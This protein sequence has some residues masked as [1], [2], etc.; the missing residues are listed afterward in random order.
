MDEMIIT[1]ARY[2]TDDDG[3]NISIVATI[4]GKRIGFPIWPG[5]REYDET[6]RQVEEG[7]LTIAEAD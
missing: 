7:T 2:I 5:N 6:M 1:D 4:N 3:N